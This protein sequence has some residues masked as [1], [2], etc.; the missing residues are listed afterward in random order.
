MPTLVVLTVIYA[1][2]RDES[3]QEN[4]HYTIWEGSP[5]LKGSYLGMPDSDALDYTRPNG[6]LQR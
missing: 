6:P 1:C 3:T 4:E 5:S 2:T